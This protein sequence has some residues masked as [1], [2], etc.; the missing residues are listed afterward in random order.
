MSA[1]SRRI[2]PVL[3]TKNA[4]MT[5]DIRKMQRRTK[6]AAVAVVGLLVLGVVGFSYTQAIKERDIVQQQKI[7]L[8]ELTKQNYDLAK[9]IKADYFQKKIECEKMA[10]SIEANVESYGRF[11]LRTTIFQLIVYSPKEN[12]CLYTTET[13]TSDGKIEYFIYNALTKAKVTSFQFP[14]QWQDYKNFLLE[15]SGGE[16]RL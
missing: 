1:T 8:D 10:Q 5:S 14:E 6:W 2:V 11:N 12:S 15:Y 9:K 4:D 3:L 7:Q 16:I 13:L